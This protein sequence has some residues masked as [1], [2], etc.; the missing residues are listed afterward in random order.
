[1]SAS[2]DAAN[3]RGRSMVRIVNVGN[4]GNA[5]G[6]PFHCHFEI[7]PGGGDATNPYPMLKAAYVSKGPVTPVFAAPVVPVP[8]FGPVVPTTVPGG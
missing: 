3:A 2:A 5:V 4:T 1:M 8:P 6:T 7:H